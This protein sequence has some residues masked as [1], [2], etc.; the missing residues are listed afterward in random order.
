MF[1]CDSPNIY[2]L[3]LPGRQHA[4]PGQRLPLVQ[5]VVCQGYPAVP[6]AGGGLLCGGGAAAP[7]DGPGA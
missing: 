2:G 5:A 4:P 7:G 1:I 6:P 3:V